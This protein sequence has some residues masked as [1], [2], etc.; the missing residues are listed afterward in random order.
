M[1]IEL[2]F[3]EGNTNNYLNDLLYKLGS[4]GVI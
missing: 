1:N 2:Y 3:I 4:M